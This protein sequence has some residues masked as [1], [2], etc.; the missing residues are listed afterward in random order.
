MSQ[1]KERFLTLS[2]E[3]KGREL[4]KYL[5]PVAVWALAFGCAV[6]WGS[7]VMPGTTFLPIAG[8]LGTALGIALGAVIMFFIGINYYNLMKKYPDA[9]GAYSYAK[10]VL[11]PDRAFLVAWFLILTYSAIIWANATALSIIAK[12]IVGDVFCFGFRYEISGYTVY[13]GELLLSAVLLFAA[14]LV[15]AAGKRVLKYVQTFLAA[16]L[17]IGAVVC[18]V[19]VAIYRGGLDK[20]A[21]A[22]SNDGSPVTQVLAIVILAPWA[23]IGFESISHSAGE[24]KFKMKK[25]LP[26]MI[27]A[28]AAGAITY[29]LLTFCATLACPDGYASWAEY[30]KDLASANGV[31]GI[32]TFYAAK[33]AMGDAGL[34]ILAF[35]AFCG[36]STGL[37]AN[38]VAVSRLL[39]AMGRDGAIP[40][41]FGRLGRRGTPK[42][43]LLGVFLFS[44]LV[45]LLGR[46]AIGWIVDVTTIGASV[47]YLYVSMCAVVLG[48]KEKNR[49]TLVYGVI[50]AVFAMMFILYFIL[51]NFWTT[52]KLA[53]ESYLILVLW[54]VAGIFVFRA[55][56]HRDKNRRY[57]KSSTVWIVFI[58][59]ISIVSLVWVRQ[60]T[61]QET[62]DIANDV[63]KYYEQTATDN[64]D[65][66]GGE[67]VE[68][69]EK[70]I[71]SRINEF[72]SFVTKNV[73]IQLALIIISVV[74]VFSI[75]SIIKKREKQIEAEKLRAEEISRAKSVFLSNMS[76]DIRTPMNA[77]IGYTALASKVDDVPDEVRDYLSKIDSSSRH[78]LSL[79]NDILDM[80]RI[81]N[82][83]MSLELEPSD[84]V[85]MFDEVCDIFAPQMK[86]KGLE[87]KSE[88]DVADRFVVCDKKRITRIL[89]NLISNSMKYTH[90]GGSVSVSLKETGCSNRRASF[91]IVV[92]DTGIGM[93][94]EF[95]AKVFEAFERERNATV[96]NTQGTGL[97][98]A[99]TKSLVEEMGGDISLVT[100]QGKGSAFTVD[101]SF[102]IAE[103]FEEKE[104]EAVAEE[105]KV[106]FT[107]KKLFLVEDNFINMEIAKKILSMMGFEI[108][109]AENGRVA[110]D[111]FSAME[112]C[113]F[114]IILT[115][116]QMPEMN[117]Y[118][119]ARAVR[120]L[121]G[122]WAKIPV[123]AMTANVFPEDIKEAKE[124]GMNGF[125]SKP[126]DVP[127]M[128]KTLRQVLSKSKQ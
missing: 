19:A 51:P 7:F 8:P 47:V 26:I 83:K 1:F 80:S 5:S 42:T 21:P 125:I 96:N 16:G 60:A 6:G 76:H 70:Y 109:S 25:S 90:S 81:E 79:I 28:L 88:R 30:I 92:A 34:G 40:G 115:D 111:K 98:M 68:K 63:T 100:E 35:A 101:L 67:S 77:V 33:A 122:D 117:G 39:F 102:E 59:L 110:M 113:P 31:A 3:D 27:F 48:M 121:G 89:L 95:A 99:I 105:E 62:G 85:A 66:P 14:Y 11:G 94:P 69:T 15:C 106:D 37:I 64:G 124:A 116:I 13:F 52:G 24:F 45:P 120:A 73:S 32:P 97:G 4:P 61:V 72:G 58:L 46:T 127:E 87:F 54:S 53:T 43:A 18:F 128:T 9:G 57:G 10:G 22:F 56:I 108:D 71:S 29:I 78:L 82:G 104:K 23:F 118:E 55:M 74:T 65:D 44:V 49:K 112:S 84:I 107:G 103:G 17:F 114:D 12:S 36:I 38:Y 93:S 86:D 126:I 50:G 91:V 41:A 20:M 119:T 75:F 2:E 123:V